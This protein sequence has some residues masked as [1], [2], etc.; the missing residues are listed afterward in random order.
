VA[1][2]SEAREMAILARYAGTDAQADLWRDAAH[3]VSRAQRQMI[4]AVREALGQK[5][6][7]YPPVDR[8]KKERKD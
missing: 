8:K 4:A 5:N 1:L 2:L 7:R 3:A 6:C